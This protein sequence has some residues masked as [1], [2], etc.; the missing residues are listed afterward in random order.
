ML[1]SVSA[2]STVVI[3]EEIGRRLGIEPG[4][5]LDWTVVEGTDTALVRRVPDRGALA[6][7]LCGLGANLA[8]GRDL[9]AELS[10]QRE[11]EDQERHRLLGE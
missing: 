5:R 2:A 3:P 7:R 6:R 4:D 1:A 11:A 9:V 10:A 8:P